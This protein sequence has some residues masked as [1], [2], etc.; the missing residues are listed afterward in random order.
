MLPYYGSWSAASP[1]SLGRQR[2]ETR[3]EALSALSFPAPVTSL[4]AE[5][6]AGLKDHDSFV[7][8]KAVFPDH[9]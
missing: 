8:V 5:A 6:S 7:L 3:S 9:D 2:A 4:L 1:K